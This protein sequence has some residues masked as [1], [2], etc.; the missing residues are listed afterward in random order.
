MNISTL[1]RPLV[2]LIHRH[3]RSLIAAAILVS[4][5]LR[6]A[7]DVVI[8][9]FE[10][11]GTVGSP[12]LDPTSYLAG[13]GIALSGVS[14]SNPM[15]FSDQAFYGTGVVL[16]SSGHNFLLQQSAVHGGSFTLNFSGAVTDF[17]FTRIAN[18]TSNSVGAWSATAYA[19]ASVV[20]SVGEGFGVGSYSP[21]VYDLS[22][23]G[24]TSVTFTGNG[25]GFAGIS[26][27]MIDDI[28]IT[29]VPDGGST[30]SLLVLAL[31]AVVGFRRRRTC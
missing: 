13:Y 11:L 2:S 10:G 8:L 15:V 9:D 29:T 17:T 5:P 22:G 30:A 20:G 24:I 6:S 27:A 25:F 21:A 1:L 19:G 16:A 3:P 18:L 14:P 12:G 23:A 26:G 7:A 31:G 28:K 4:L